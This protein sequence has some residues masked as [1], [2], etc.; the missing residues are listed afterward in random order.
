MTNK[1]PTLYLAGRM[2]GL[3]DLGRAA[4][5]EAE[6]ELTKQGYTVINP[7][8][9]PTTLKPER[10]M[11]I[12]MAMIDAA[13]ALCLLPGWKVSQGAQLEWQYA[14]YQG[15]RITALCRTARGGI[16]IDV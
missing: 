12:C 6:A 9:L 7:A 15:K 14:K 13:D 16:L 2:R 4:F 11:P 10:Y 8:C 1:K 5:R 3:P